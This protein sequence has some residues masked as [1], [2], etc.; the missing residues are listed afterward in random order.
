MPEDTNIKQDEAPVN[1]IV[2]DTDTNTTVNTDAVVPTP[3]VPADSID[4]P[5]V[6]ETDSVQPDPVPI[7]ANDVQ[8]EPVM[9][10]IEP[11]E[12]DLEDA[13]PKRRFG[14]VKKHELNFLRDKWI[15]SRIKDDELMEYLRLEEKRDERIRAAKEAR[16]KRLM[17]A[18]ILIITLL[19][20]VS[21]VYLLKD[22]P[23]I[24]T[25]ILYIGGII[26]GIWF[27]KNPKEKR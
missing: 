15:L 18:F 5:P 4:I 7:I 19:S 25:N 3:D 17:T 20:I 27:F 16:D 9:D 11:D 26:A 8:R 13:L 21:V 2:T 1:D 6:S 12:E 24:L 23:T 22:S 14:H 10:E